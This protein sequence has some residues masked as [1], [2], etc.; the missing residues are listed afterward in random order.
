MTEVT[1]K[2]CFKCGR[3]LPITEFYSH[4]QMGDGHL[5]K[6]KKCTKKDVHCNYE[7]KIKDEN[8]VE[9]E[10]KRGRE[11][12]KR[13]YSGEKQHNDKNTN[14]VR[15]SI[16][17]KLG[18]LNNEIELHH[19][20]YN[21]LFSVIALNRRFHAQLH[22]MLIYNKKERIFYVSQER[23]LF[24]SPS[25]AL[26]SLRSQRFLRRIRRILF[27]DLLLVPIRGHCRRALF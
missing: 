15:I 22:Q 10:R 8:F 20:N 4:P 7:K 19:W 5:N 13:L 6:C 1:F 12:Y 11:K 9:N 18:K 16:E 27:R 21:D 3:L 23:P 17:R 14:S 2:K 26:Y 24:S 25:F